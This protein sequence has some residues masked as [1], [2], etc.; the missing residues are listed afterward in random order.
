L[1]ANEKM[2]EH[3]NNMIPLQRMAEPVEMAGLVMLLASDAGSYMT[4]GVYAADGG[5][6]ISG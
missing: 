6:L 2:L 3:Y 4:G 1:W 5:Y